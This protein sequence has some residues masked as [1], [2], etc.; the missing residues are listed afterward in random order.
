MGSFSW[1]KADR[2]TKVAN[3][4]GEKP[5]KLLIPKEFGGGYI[6]D[7]Y[8]DYGRVGLT[9]DLQPKYDMFELLAFW[10]AEGED[11]EKL[12]YDGEF[13][14]MKEIDQYTNKNRTIGINMGSYDYEVDTL[15]YPLKLVS[16]SYKGTYEDCEGRSYSDPN[17]GFTSLSWDEHDRI[18][19]VRKGI[20]L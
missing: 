12:L 8:Q 7:H 5:F 4:V 17:Q 2:L 16:A 3:V 10:N 14:L 18:L 19:E 15:K 1:T 6:K 11:R 13:P 20:R 9:R